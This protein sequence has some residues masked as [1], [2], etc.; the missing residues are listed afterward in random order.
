M[1]V[2]AWRWNRSTNS[3]ARYLSQFT[4]TC[5]NLSMPNR[6][7]ASDE[8]DPQKPERLVNGVGQVGDVASFGGQVL[9][10]VRERLRLWSS[11]TPSK[12]NR[13]WLYWRLLT[14]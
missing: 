5:A 7:G 13:Y 1:R 11:E 8:A 6:I 14:F 9:A 3:G 4:S 12:D 2:W 10:R